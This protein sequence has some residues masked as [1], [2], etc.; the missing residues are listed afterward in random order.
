MIL[1][2]KLQSEIGVANDGLRFREMP[3]A[4]PKREEA[5]QEETP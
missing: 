1:A 3:G 4:F 2:G 5:P